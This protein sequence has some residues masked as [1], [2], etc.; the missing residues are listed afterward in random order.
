ML[1]KYQMQ[2]W[3]LQLWT[4]VKMKRLTFVKI[5]QIISLFF[6]L[7]FNRL[8]QLPEL[9]SIQTFWAAMTT[10][11]TLIKIIKVDLNLK[12]FNNNNNKNGAQGRAPEGSVQFK[13]NSHA[14]W[15]GPWERKKVTCLGVWWKFTTCAKN[16]MAINSAYIISKNLPVFKTA[17]C[18]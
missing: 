16:G 7:H 10:S 8:S 4:Q 3:E 13:S 12:G 1:F 2:T 15:M 9:Q 14:R 18:G 5:H 17:K 11:G 6:P